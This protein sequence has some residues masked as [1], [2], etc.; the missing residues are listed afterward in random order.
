MASRIIPRRDAIE[1][2]IDR[3]GIISLCQPDPSGNDDAIVADHPS[4]VPRLIKF[5]R[6]AAKEALAIDEPEEGA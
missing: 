1:V 5:L 3:D 6:D 2:C 4:D